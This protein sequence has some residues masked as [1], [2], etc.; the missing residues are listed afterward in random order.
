M[1]DNSQHRRSLMKG[2][3]WES[4]SYILTILITYWYLQSFSTSVRLTSILFVVKIVFFFLHER[5]W[6]QVTWGKISQESG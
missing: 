1:K 5:L 4:F 6:H 2:L 3:C